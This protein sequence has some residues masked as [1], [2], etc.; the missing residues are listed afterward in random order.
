MPIRESEKKK[1]DFRNRILVVQSKGEE[2]T[3]TGQAE[4]VGYDN[5]VIIICLYNY[6]EINSVT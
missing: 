3:V 1:N 6:C 2:Y 4:F 5:G